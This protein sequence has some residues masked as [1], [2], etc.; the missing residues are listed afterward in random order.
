MAN[1]EILAIVKQQVNEGKSREVIVSNLIF[2]GWK[3]SEIEEAFAQLAQLGEINSAYARR[4]ERGILNATR[5]DG[6]RRVE[7]LI[8]VPL[9]PRAKADVISDIV[10]AY[11]RKAFM[12]VVLVFV[13]L[14]GIVGGYFL[15]SN[16]SGVI[17]RKSFE[18]VAQSSFSYN[19]LMSGGVIIDYRDVDLFKRNILTLS[20][21]SLIIDGSFAPDAK[22]VFGTS[23][24]VLLPSSTSSDTSTPSWNMSALLLGD[25]DVYAQTTGLKHGP[26]EWKSA[27]ERIGQRWIKLSSSGSAQRFPFLGPTGMWNDFFSCSTLLAGS[28]YNLF[29]LFNQE[30][31]ITSIKRLG[32]ENKNG[33]DAYHFVVTLD[34]AAIK[35]DILTACIN[36]GLFADWSALFSGEWN[37]YISKKTSL[38]VALE[39]NNIL[40]QDTNHTL[41][42]ISFAVTFSRFGEAFSI[43]APQSFLLPDQ[44]WAIIT[45]TGPPTSTATSTP[46]STH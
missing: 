27:I 37:V 2:S 34:G 12:W 41:S 24:V 11:K 14:G 30:G 9:P 18:K 16:M 33:E 8:D 20:R 7:E 23:L 4:Q 29:S 38:P 46:S 1:E 28:R 40:Q 21:E 39:K 42:I 17:V 15:Y 6:P 13:V 26:V 31:V 32:S 3:F 45:D 36:Q 25:G 22:G 10:K 43:Q 5:N 35:D 19:A 44:A